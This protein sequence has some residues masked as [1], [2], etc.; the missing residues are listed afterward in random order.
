MKTLAISCLGWIA[1]GFFVASYFFVRPA[2]LRT[3]QML[4]A[5]LWVLYGALIGAA[6]VV[7]S[8]VLVIAAAGWTILHRA[9][10][11]LQDDGFGT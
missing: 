7:V 6:P 5:L 1:T 9:A 2:L 4:G 10:P 3:T 8:N 11:P